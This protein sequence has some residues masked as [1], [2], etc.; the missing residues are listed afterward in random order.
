MQKNWRIAFYSPNDALQRKVNKNMVIPYTKVHG[1]K[2][3][4]WISGFDAM[5]NSLLGLAEYY[6]VKPLPVIKD[7]MLKVGRGLEE[8][9]FGSYDQYPFGAH[10][11][12][13]GS[14]T[15]WHAWGSGQSFALAK[16]G[17]VLKKKNGLIPQNK[18]R[19][20]GLA[21]SLCPE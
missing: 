16:A 3:L 18:K 6:S 2:I 19:T 7:S 4:A 10:L 20:N 5:S 12:W 15:L 11:D 1:Y 17:A 14:P 8:Y 21:I 13:E 9:Q